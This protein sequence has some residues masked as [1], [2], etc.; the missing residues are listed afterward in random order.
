M[1][2]RQLKNFPKTCVKVT[3]IIY[4]IEET[5]D[6]TYKGNGKIQ[7]ISLTPP[8]TSVIFIVLAKTNALK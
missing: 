4:E 2:R 1:S 5:F 3:L 6:H 7:F 8:K